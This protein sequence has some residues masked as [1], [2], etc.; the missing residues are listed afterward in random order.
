MA[1]SRSTVMT[2]TLPLIRAA[3]IAPI[4]IW[5]R[6][7]GRP[8]EARLAA[9]GLPPDIL[10]EPERPIAFRSAVRFAVSAA[11]AEGPDLGARSIA[12]TGLAPFATIGRVALSSASPREAFAR[13]AVAFGRFNSHVQFAVERRPG[14]VVL[15]HL[16]TVRLDDE[17]LHQAQQT[18]VAAMLAALA[19]AGRGG[20]AVTSAALT[21]HPEH[22]VAH[23]A[24]HFGFAPQPSPTRAVE[25]A[26]PDAALDRPYLRRARPRAEPA[27][28]EDWPALRGEGG[29]AASV[30]AVLP[31][32]LRLRAAHVEAVA[33]LAFMSPRTLQRRLAGE[34]TSLSQLADE[35]RRAM[36]VTDLAAARRL[37]GEV[38]G[39]LG[40]AETSALTR[41]VR[42]WTG[43]PPRALR[44]AADRAG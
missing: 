1:E 13:L 9:A 14:G 7:H 42:R 32:L 44:A 23:L 26:I 38:A 40:Y 10:D 39:E 18:L 19:G 25:I 41:A 16:Y 12:E 34:G 30:R 20:P 37:V 43:R 29:L 36:A 11:R 22:G 8:L 31:Q 28:T 21:P 3:S 15:H 2:Q 35:T 5:L 27:A 4:A 6:A 24:P 17:A 33:D